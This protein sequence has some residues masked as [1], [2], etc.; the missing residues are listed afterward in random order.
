M[1][2]NFQTKQKAKELRRLGHSLL[3]ISLEI[4]VSKSTISAWVSSIKLDQ[5]AIERL[6]FISNRSFRKSKQTR[7]RNQLVLLNKLKKKVK[8]QFNQKNFDKFDYKLMA[9]MLFWGEGNKSGSYMSFINSDPVMI[10]CYL[11]LL[12][13]SFNL[14]EKKFRA[15]IHIHQYHNERE[16]KEYWSEITK[17]PLSQ[18]SKSYL[19]PN[20]GKRKKTGYKGCLRIRYYDSSLEKELTELYTFLPS[21][22]KD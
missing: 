21:I 14:D 6:D 8:S 4:G 7:E 20:S 2:Y 11:K 18:F 19:K 13:K 15:L 17:I 9:A 5:T 22:L 10:S 12:R 3:E 16:L 1:A